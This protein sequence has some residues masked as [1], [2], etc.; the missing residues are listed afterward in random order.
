MA[1]VPWRTQSQLDQFR[2]DES[3]PATVGNLAQA[4]HWTPPPAQSGQPAA[5]LYGSP[6]VSGG[7]VFIGSNTGVFYGL[8]ETTGARLW[9]RNLGHSPN[10]TCSSRGIS[11]T[12]TVAPDAS[13]GGASTA[14]VSSP[15]GALFAL[16]AGAGAV[17]WKKQVTSTSTTANAYFGWSSPT[18]VAGHIYLGLSSQCDQ[19]LVRGGVVEVNQSTG[20]ILHRYWSI[21]SGKVGA[22]RLDQRRHNHRRAV[23]L[24]DHWQRR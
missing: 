19:P 11:S 17:V 16:N 5:A 4:W 9:S 24:C 1:G 3:T 13:R 10:L 18:V 23:G 20:A 7:R 15:T 14:Y 12:A 2:Y 8:S 22:E 6:T 21:G